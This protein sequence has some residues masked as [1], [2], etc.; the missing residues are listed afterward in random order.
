MLI[1]ILVTVLLAAAAFA[2][3]SAWL[4][5]DDSG[6]ALLVG[7]LVTVVMFAAMFAGKEAGKKQ[8]RLP[9]LS[10]LCKG[11][12]D[13]R[14]KVAWSVSKDD[15]ESLRKSLEDDAKCDVTVT[16]VKVPPP[17]PSP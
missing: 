4:I 8:E 1:A 7:V 3:F 10:G 12:P 15:F 11:S 6:R 2:V 9:D 13:S 17:F 5:K 16:K 14:I